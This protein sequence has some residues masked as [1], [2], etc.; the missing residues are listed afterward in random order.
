MGEAEFVDSRTAPSAGVE[1]PLTY[2]SQW[3]GRQ[4]LRSAKFLKGT[5]DAYSNFV[6]RE[7]LG[8]TLVRRVRLLDGSGDRGGGLDGRSDEYLTG[9]VGY[10]APSE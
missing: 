4:A 9:D 5:A 1:D 10:E 6:G 2:L 8:G 3:I 7:C